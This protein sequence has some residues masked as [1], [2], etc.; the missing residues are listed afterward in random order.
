[1][2]NPLSTLVRYRSARLTIRVLISLAMIYIVALAILLAIEDRLIYHPRSA[3]ERWQPS[4]AG[5]AVEDVK[6][7][8]DAGTQI[9]ARWFPCPDAAGAV[10]IC[11]SRGGNLST[12]ISDA[13]LD[14]WHRQIKTSVLIVDYPGYGRSA[15]RPSE[16]GCYEAARAAHLWLTETKGIASDD[17][18][19]YGRSLGSAV[20]VDLASRVPHRALILV[21]PF[22][23]LPAVASSLVP[24]LPARLLMRNRFPS[25][26]KIRCC[27]SPVFILHGT[28]DRQVPFVLGKQL[29]EQAK[30]P[31]QL[32]V[33][34]GGDHGNCVRPEF[35][36]ALRQFLVTSQ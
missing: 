22:P 12:E 6:L 17:M 27:S 4:P 23:S 16:P 32:M 25:A 19:I 18:L 13:E 15:G 3:K 31:K 11:H 35:F 26:E 1:M 2:V 21:S 29:F 36:S 33:V 20:A 28:A 7:Q 24:I 10:L 8:T 14:G 30:E 9:H 5:R 34:E